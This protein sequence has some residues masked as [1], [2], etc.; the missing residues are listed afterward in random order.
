MK[1]KMDINALTLEQLYDLNEK[2]CQRIDTLIAQQNLNTLSRLRL[3]MKVTFD[4]KNGP[5]IGTVIKINQKSIIVV[6]EGGTRQWKIAPGLVNP[7][8]DLN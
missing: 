6:S 5:E 1:S 7:V 2:I 4:S 3:G 8:Q